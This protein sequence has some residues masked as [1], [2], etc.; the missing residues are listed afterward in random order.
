MSSSS[1]VQHLQCPRFNTFLDHKSSSSSSSSSATTWRRGRSTRKSLLLRGVH[2]QF[3][4]TH[5]QLLQ[6]TAN[7]LRV[8]RI[9]AVAAV[10]D[11][12]NCKLSCLVP[13]SV[14]VYCLHLMVCSPK[15]VDLIS[16]EANRQIVHILCKTQ[17]LIMASM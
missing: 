13:P 9:Q 7:L 6:N 17:H 16:S 14:F 11:H 1:S 4:F 2:P 15:N 12:R 8:H 5:Q 10:S 3:H